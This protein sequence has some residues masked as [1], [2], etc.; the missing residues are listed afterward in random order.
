MTEVGLVLGGGGVVGQAYH[1]G[2]L[3]ALEHDLG[4]DPRDAT[5]LVGTSA[6]AVTAAALRHGVAASDLAAWCVEAPL[7]GV[8]ADLAARINVRPE[9]APFRPFEVLRPGRLPGLGLI[10]RAA[11]APWRIRP[12]TWALTMLRDGDVDL[13][14][15][16][17]LLDEL[18]H[19]WPAEELWI[20]AVRRDD[21]MRITF[22][23][24]G[25]APTTPRAAVAASCAVPGYFKPVVIDG[26]SYIDGGAH[27]P[28]N[29]DVL[30]RRRL[31]LVI[32]VAPL[33]GARGGWSL[34][35]ELRRLA[36]RRLRQEVATLERVGHTVVVIEPGAP[37][38]AVMGRD[39]MDRAVVPDVVRESFLDAGARLRGLD[40]ATRGALTR[41]LTASR[42][43]GAGGTTPA[44]AR[45]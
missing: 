24:P 32:V 28:T 37:V 45:P 29:A 9:L 8:A 43:P 22:G 31:D 17:A 42:R 23:R 11:R 1:S 12:A 35:G 33:G 14:D 44:A 21:G 2:V 41:A 15:T 39:V 27:S 20:C 30:R 34:D 3:A 40:P 7:W 5:V 26:R 38:V 10:T 18:P 36:S 16:V 25:T 6:G 13:G 19:E 4:W